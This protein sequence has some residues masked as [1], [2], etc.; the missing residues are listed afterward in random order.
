MARAA[1]GMAITSM[2]SMGSHAIP[3]ASRSLQSFC[4]RSGFQ[5]KCTPWLSTVGSMMMPPSNIKLMAYKDTPTFG[6]YVSKSNAPG[7]SLVRTF[8]GP[9]SSTG[10]ALT[11]EM[12]SSM[13]V[14]FPK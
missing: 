1:F 5:M 14:G 7:M 6:L 4:R 12:Q 9:I 8:S 2:P 3:P 11:A 10:C 13:V